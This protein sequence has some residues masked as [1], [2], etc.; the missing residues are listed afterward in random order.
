MLPVADLGL[1]PESAA[2][3]HGETP[4]CADTP[5]TSACRTSETVS[6]FAVVV[7][8]YA[9]R[10]WGAGVRPGAV[11]ALIKANHLDIQAIQCAVVR[12]GAL[13]ALLSVAMDPADLLHCLKEL[14]RPH[15]L[16]DADGA[17]ALRPW[18]DQLGDI[19]AGVL[20]L[21]PEA[22]LTGAVELN[23]PGTHRVTRRPG[24]DPTLI[25]H[26]SG[27]TGK[28]KLLVHTVDSL[29][30]HVAPQINVVQSLDYAGISAKCLSFVHVRMSTG[31][32]T[33][34]NTGV[35]FLGISSPDPAS[36]RAALLRHRPQTLEAQPNMFL[37]WETLA[38]ETPNPFSTAERYISSFDALHPRTLRTLLE[39]TD[40]PDPTFI[41]AYG[42]TET[43][44]VTILMTR[45]SDIREPGRLHSRDVGV[46]FPGMEI[47]V[48]DDTG[49]VLPPGTPGQI[50]VRTPARAESMIGRPPLPG[51]DSWWP[52]ADIGMLRPDGHLE[53][54]DRQVDQVPGVASTLRAEDVL[55]DELPDLAEVVIVGRDG[56]V[57]A[58]AATADGKPV[59]EDR[60][61]QARAKAGLPED[62]RVD[63]RPWE[64]FPLTGTM[65]VRRHRLLPPGTLG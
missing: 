29:Y 52:M 54:L 23:E 21:S 24:T 44:P 42:Q 20:T 56:T 34:L 39:A 61:Q 50:E 46:A 43:G 40:H 57:T 30:A 48:V 18:Q 35:P 51:R 14:Q 13:P 15:V 7:A 3:H 32:L 31:I 37:R 22:A 1:L 33:A 63:Y 8:D 28:P 59:D 2:E 53:L 65:K 58:V 49:A 12:V 38:R 11:V 60:W 27:T 41:Q 19:A 16:T 6:D 17:A 62:T 45:R 25:T 10:L 36:V 64:E 47:R 4:L 26:S 55:L 9:D 5:W